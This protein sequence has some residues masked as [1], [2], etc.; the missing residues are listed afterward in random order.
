MLINGV[1]N[2]KKERGMTSFGVVSRLRKIFDQKKIGH[3]GTLDPDAVGVLPVCLGRATHL[4]ET[5]SRGTKSYEAVLLL[6]VSTDTQDI[7]GA[8][9]KEQEVTVS[10]EEVRRAVSSFA[11]RQLQTPPM[12]SALKVGGK[13]L[14]DLARR[15]IEV[16]RKAREVEFS[17]IEILAVDLPRVSFKVTCSHG[18]YIR[19][20]CSDIGDRLGC[21]GC[22]ESLIRT[23]V[24]EFDIGDALTLDEIRM[25]VEAGDLSF[26]LPIDHFYR[27]LPAYTLCGESLRIVL[28]GQP[29]K[30]RDLSPY[31]P[32]DGSPDQ[33]SWA[34]KEAS[35]KEEALKSLKAATGSPDQRSWAEMEGQR[36]RLYTPSGELIGIYRCKGRLS[37]LE[38]YY[39]SPDSR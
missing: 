14:V 7:S 16:E 15:G 28:N 32:G 24:E 10:V 11:G 38:Q 17:E 23:R 25:R 18:T 31:V 37:C 36:F 26:I 5:L 34:E 35:S 13:K 30:T 27:E 21:G 9:L 29:A 2:V 4:V 20:L 22:M 1:I 3:T 8:V 19:T 12:Y 6:G 39:Y 33:R